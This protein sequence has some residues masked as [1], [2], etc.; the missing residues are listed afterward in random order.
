MLNNVQIVSLHI[1]GRI[2][3]PSTS[4]SLV[5]HEIGNLHSDKKYPINCRLNGFLR[6]RRNVLQYTTLFFLFRSHSGNKAI[7]LLIHK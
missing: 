5:R 2:C 1:R 3:Y 4:M 7:L 6:P